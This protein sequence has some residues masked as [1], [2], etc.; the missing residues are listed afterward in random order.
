MRKC[1]LSESPPL[2]TDICRKSKSQVFN[3]VFR[4]DY[5]GY[6]KTEILVDY[7]QLTAGDKPAFNIH[8]QRF[9][10][11]LVQFDNCSL[12][13]LDNFIHQQLGSSHLDFDVEGD[14]ENFF[15][16]GI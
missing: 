5:L 7:D 3:T 10:G 8:I 6:A 4:S 11:Q 16:A 15:Q 1:G 14:I 9:S 12:T 13:E 2:K